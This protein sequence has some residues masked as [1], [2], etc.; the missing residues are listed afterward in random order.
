MEINAAL[1]QTILAIYFILYSSSSISSSFILFQQKHIN[2]KH[3]E[4][5][6]ANFVKIYSIIN[7]FVLMNALKYIDIPLRSERFMV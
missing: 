3:G 5:I 2:N 7:T 6:N 4:Q 1:M